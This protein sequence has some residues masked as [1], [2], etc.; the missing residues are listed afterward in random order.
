MYECVGSTSCTR[1]RIFLA[2]FDPPHDCNG[3]KE[4]GRQYESR[5]AGGCCRRTIESLPPF[6]GVGVLSK[7]GD[8]EKRARKIVRMG[9]KK[10]SIDALFYK[11]EREESRERE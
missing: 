3:V 9:R 11:L 4:K 10:K 7:K 5:S 1:E 6:V 2:H 8:I